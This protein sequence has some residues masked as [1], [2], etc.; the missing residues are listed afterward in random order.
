MSIIRLSD[1]CIQLFKRIQWKLSADDAT[2]ESRFHV[3]RLRGT[4]EGRPRVD[5]EV[6]RLGR[7][8]PCQCDR[9]NCSHTSCG[10]RSNWVNNIIIKNALLL[11][12]KYDEFKGQKDVIILKV[13]L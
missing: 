1:I 6:V 8:L 3:P 7:L 12:L 2:L 4:Q 5:G 11:P 9:H 10:P 13:K